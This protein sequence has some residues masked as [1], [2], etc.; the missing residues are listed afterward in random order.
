MIYIKYNKFPVYLLKKMQIPEIIPR[1][2]RTE[3]VG[4]WPWDLYSSKVSQMVFMI[5]YG[6]KKEGKPSVEETSEPVFRPGHI[7]IPMSPVWFFYL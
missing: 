5:K 3:L 2:T 7:L 6:K 4:R 1:S